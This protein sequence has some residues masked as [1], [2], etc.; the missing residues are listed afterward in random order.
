M[1]FIVQHQTIEL[2]MKL[3]LHELTAAIRCIAANDLHSALLKPH[4]HRADL[5]A[6]VE[7]A[8]NAPSLYDE[9][10]VALVM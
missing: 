8:F 7:T 5:L 2:W 1:L 4:S 9:A 6:I 10:P 3:L